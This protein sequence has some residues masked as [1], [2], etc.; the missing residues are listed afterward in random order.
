MRPGFQTARL[1]RELAGGGCFCSQ[2]TVSPRGHSEGRE[3]GLGDEQ[4]AGVL[5]GTRVLRDDLGVSGIF[6]DE[7]KRGV[8]S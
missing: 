4:R 5:T 1:W 6:G 7:E 8:L 2:C 3:A